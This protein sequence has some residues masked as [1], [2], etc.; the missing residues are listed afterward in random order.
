MNDF[1]IV[2]QVVVMLYVWFDTDAYVQWMTFLRLNSF[3]KFHK[4]REQPIGHLV[5]KDYP[6]YL[7][8]E[9]P[10]NFLIK[11]I[12]CPVCLSTWL[13]IIPAMAWDLWNVLPTNIVATWVLYFGLRKF[14]L[15][16]N[17]SNHN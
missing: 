6:S 3:K 15:W 12:T 17:E 1:N 5:A 14:I 7:L 8:W 16:C 4:I 10:N 13:N 11:L 9:Y 2:L